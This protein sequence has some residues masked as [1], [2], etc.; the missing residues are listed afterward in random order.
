M[1]EF[2]YFNN[3]SILV[4]SNREG[5]QKNRPCDLDFRLHNQ[6]NEPNI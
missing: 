2:I 3:I 4:V 1:V 6:K 5:N